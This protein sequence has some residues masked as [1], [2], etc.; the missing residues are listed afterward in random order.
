[1]AAYL[2]TCGLTA[3]TPGSAPGSVLSNECGKSCLLSMRYEIPG[4]LIALLPML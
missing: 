2:V 4:L 1:M 3:Y